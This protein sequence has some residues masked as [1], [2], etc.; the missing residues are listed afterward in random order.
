LFG[1]LS[2]FKYNELI[3]LVFCVSEDYRTNAHRNIK[4]KTFKHSSQPSD[5]VGKLQLWVKELKRQAPE[6][7]IS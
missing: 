6:I 3:L 2:I 5:A 4:D 1:M 7:T